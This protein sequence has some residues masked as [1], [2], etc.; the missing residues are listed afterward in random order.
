MCIIIETMQRTVEIR[1]AMIQSSVEEARMVFAEAHKDAGCKDVQQFN[2]FDKEGGLTILCN[3]PLFGEASF[4][5]FP[6]E[7]Q[8]LG[9]NAEHLLS[10]SHPLACQAARLDC[11][12]NVT[13]H[14]PVPFQVFRSL[15]CGEATS[16]TVQ[17]PVNCK[18]NDDGSANFQL[19]TAHI[20]L[21]AARN[22]ALHETSAYTYFNLMGKAA[23]QALLSSMRENDVSV[24]NVFPMDD[25]DDTQVSAEAVI[26]FLH[27]FLSCLVTGCDVLIHIP[28]FDKDG[29]ALARFASFALQYKQAPESI[30]VLGLVHN[31]DQSDPSDEEEKVTESHYIVSNKAIKFIAPN[32]VEVVPAAKERFLPPGEDEEEDYDD[33]QS[34]CALFQEEVHEAI[35]ADIKKAADFE[36]ETTTLFFANLLGYKFP[37]NVVSFR[38]DPASPSLRRVC[39]RHD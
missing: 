4:F 36:A 28:A 23:F 3:L 35:V 8:H 1:K 20:A 38:C 37:K 11:I 30:P 19:Q 9:K 12:M 26:D 29:K 32:G 34:A 7:A 6:L 17:V 33:W 27:Q 24:K 21:S 15:G 13:Q 31:A 39:P 5:M 25:E 10:V 14:V 22:I 2:I 18:K 16:A